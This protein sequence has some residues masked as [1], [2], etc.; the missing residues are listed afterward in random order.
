MLDPSSPV[1]ISDEP[2]DLVPIHLEM[3]F[4]GMPL[5]TAT[6]FVVRDVYQTFLVTNWHNVTGLE[7]DSGRCKSPTGGIPNQIV[8]AAPVQSRDAEGL[9]CW[10]ELTISLYSDDE[11]RRPRWIEHPVYGRRVDVVAIP[12]SGLEYSALRVANGEFADTED[13]PLR[14]GVDVFILGFP[15]DLKAGA[16]WP[17][18]KRGSI[19][20]NPAVDIDDLPK[21]LIDTATREGMSGAP[22]YAQETRFWA[23]DTVRSQL[24]VRFGVGRKLL[25]IYSGRLGDDVFK[26]QLGIVWKT[27]VILEILVA[28]RL[29]PGL[30]NEMVYDGQQLFSQ[31][32]LL[33]EFYR[34]QEEEDPY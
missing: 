10:K 34:K 25:G 32:S 6:G 20:S 2:L 27:S 22:V 30:S 7:P 24:D 18:W 33:E 8:L 21:V 12:L 5:S 4:D 26:A 17:V 28:A 23:A 14:S 19:A 13:V 1:K 9:V 29:Y 15:R 11:T 16:M 31:R 3:K